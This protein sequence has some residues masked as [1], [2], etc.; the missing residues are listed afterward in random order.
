[1]TADLTAHPLTLTLGSL[2]L[3][4]NGYQLQMTVP[5]QAHTLCDGTL[6]KT[7]LP[8][9]PCTLTVSGSLLRTNAETVIPA[10]ESALRNH[11]GFS[12]IFAGITF[13]GMQ[14]TEVLSDVKELA[15]TAGFRLT[16]TGVT[17][18]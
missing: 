16:F 8:E 18:S 10:L 4:I 17:A 5:V 11:T 12:F 2:T 6:S 13:T 7:L 9:S 15:G 3:N 1:M 14:L